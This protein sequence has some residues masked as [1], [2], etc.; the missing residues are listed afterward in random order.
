MER[1][2]ELDEAVTRYLGNQRREGDE[3]KLNKKSVSGLLHNI[4]TTNRNHR[5]KS[6][7][8]Q[9]KGTTG[10]QKKESKLNV[11]GVAGRTT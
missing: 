10:R 8:I 6:I 1:W 4:R 3:G 2:V 9:K 5:N 7:F 11:F